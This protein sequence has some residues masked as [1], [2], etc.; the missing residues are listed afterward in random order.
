MTITNQ[1]NKTIQVGNGTTATFNFAFPIFQASDLK[2]YKYLTSST[3]TT[4]TPLTITT[5]Y[6]VVISSTTEGGSVTFVETPLATETIAIIRDL[7]YTQTTDIDLNGN[8]PEVDVE[9]ALDK[10]NMLAIQLKEQTDRALKISQF[11]T[12]DFSGEVQAPDENKALVW[13]TDLSGAFYIGVS[14]NDP[15][16]QVANAT[17]QAGIATAQAG[18]ATTQAGIATTQAGIAT[19]Q[20]GLS[21]GFADNS[22]EWATKTDGIVSTTDYSA[23]AYAIG[24]TGTATNNAKYWSEEAQAA[25]QSVNLVGEIRIYGGSTA[26]TGF[27]LCNGDAISRTTYAGLFGVIG[28]TYGVGDNSTTFNIPDLRDKFPQGANS[29]LGTTKSA[30]LPNITGNFTTYNR[31]NIEYS[32]DGA[33]TIGTSTSINAT[34]SAGTGYITPYSFNASNSNSIYGNSTTVQPPA[35]CVNY[36]IKY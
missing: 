10:N 25:A 35:L 26:P 1:T 2:V 18:I 27:F 22:E 28:T 3:S 14:T 33:I 11:F 5:D 13:K 34:T 36:I 21:S 20:A 19:T 16:E 24:G 29:N 9:N 12:E 30:G 32:A 17:A 6:T 4:H 23:K 7:S 31:N 15:D 8:F